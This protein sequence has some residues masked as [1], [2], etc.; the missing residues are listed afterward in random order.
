MPSSPTGAKR[1]R[2]AMV[3][4]GDIARKGYLPLVGADP[5]IELVLVTRDPDTRRHLSAQWR[6]AA[7]YRR[8]EEALHAEP[9]LDAAFVHAATAA[10]PSLTRTLIAAG[11][12]TLVDKPLAYTAEESHALV[13]LARK[14]GVSLAVAFNRRFAPAYA[15]L[16]AQPGLDTIVLTKNRRNS[17][18]DARV[19]I[20]DDFIHVVDTLRYMVAPEPDQVLVS[21]RGDSDGRLARIA[22]T[23]QQGHRLG[24]G[25]MDRDSGA[26]TEVLEGMGPGRATQIWDLTHKTIREDGR[27][28]TE[29]RDG[30]A[31]VALQRGFTA[32]VGDFLS[33]VRAGTV[34]DAGDADATHQLCETI[35]AQ[36]QAQLAVQ[37]LG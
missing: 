18:D 37:R 21:A 9:Q 27:T 36:A 32:M 22:V 26:T 8:I 5:D 20:F 11:V 30:W 10:H 16:A 2:V 7:S 4:L 31:S 13:A 23:L 15:Q 25:I 34:L 19:V 6:T 14:A 29:T 33:A 35:L 24:I 3:G 12:P 1:L 28:I 17:A